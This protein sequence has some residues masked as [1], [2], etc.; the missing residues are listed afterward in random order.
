MWIIRGPGWSIS[1]HTRMPDNQDMRAELLELGVLIGANQTVAYWRR[2]LRLTQRCS[3]F[4][5][6]SS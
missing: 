4:T 3:R 5:S 1:K 6:D 2:V